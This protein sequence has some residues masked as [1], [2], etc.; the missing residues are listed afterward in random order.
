MAAG[1]QI[2]AWNI[3]AVDLLICALLGNNYLQESYTVC[4]ANSYREET[5]ALRR[6]LPLRKG[7]SISI[8]LQCRCG[9]AA[10]GFREVEL[11]VLGMQRALKQVILVFKLLLWKSC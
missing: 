3:P 9:L 1:A 7:Q 4:S 11:K 5:R 10:P 6:C 8:S 2:G